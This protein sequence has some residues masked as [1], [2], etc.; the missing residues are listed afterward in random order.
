M[1]YNRR[2][3]KSE[4]ETRKLV[5]R[6][7]KTKYGPIVLAVLVILAA[8]GYLYYNGY[9]GGISADAYAEYHFIDVG[10][11]DASLILTDEAAVLVDCGTL[12]QSYIVLDYVKKYTDFRNFPAEPS[13]LQLLQMTV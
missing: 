8:L 4:N 11:G 6:L 9:F 2:D 7:M 3:A 1:R 12:E 13:M 5:S 10:Q